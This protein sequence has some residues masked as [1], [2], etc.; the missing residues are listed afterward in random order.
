MDIVKI[1]LIGLVG[2]LVAAPLKSY[3][4]EYGIYIGFAACLLILT[5][6]V[7][8]FVRILSG[9][10]M[11]EQYLGDSFKY[12]SVL[13]KAVGAAYVCEFCSAICRDAGYIGIAGQVEAM[14][15]MYILLIGMPVLFALMESIQT[16]AG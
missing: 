4:N 14:G 10:E 16:L 15:K 13:L 1:G 8:Y 7:N 9:M 12:L 5:Y 3:K 2:V 6:S 11:L